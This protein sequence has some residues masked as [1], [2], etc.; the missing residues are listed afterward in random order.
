MEPTIT[1]IKIGDIEIPKARAFPKGK[2]KDPK[3]LERE[4]ERE[5]EAQE[6][7]QSIRFQGLLHP[8]GVRKTGRFKY[9]LIYGRRRVKAVKSLGHDEIKATVYSD[10]TDEYANVLKATENIH[11]QKLTE[12]QKD[13]ARRVWLKLFEEK[14]KAERNAFDGGDTNVSRND[15]EH[16]DSET[17]PK[18]TAYGAIKAY[19]ELTGTSRPDAERDMRITTK[20][21]EEEVGT[22]TDNGAGK[23]DLD[24]VARIADPQARSKV[25]ERVGSGEKVNDAIAQETSAPDGKV[26]RADGS[27]VETERSKAIQKMNDQEWVERE[28]STI[29]SKL[30]NPEAFDAAAIDYRK[31]KDHLHEL[32]KIRIASNSAR[33]KNGLSSTAMA[34]KVYGVTSISHPQAWLLC[35]E[36]DSTGQSDQGGPCANCNGDGFK[37]KTE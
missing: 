24:S 5:S 2:V 10:I 11:R 15:G 26:K 13:A 25:V 21:T 14:L 34:R 6:L 3:R 32:K 30:R 7:A 9:D 29:R 31:M 28:C 23:T 12:K 27:I 36:C 1:T 20:L 17:T 8:I 33:L 37:I 16:A 4:A 18:R 35:G 22:L 19:Q